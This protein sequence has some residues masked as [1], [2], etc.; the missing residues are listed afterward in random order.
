MSTLA[1]SATNPQGAG[2]TLSFPLFSNPDSIVGLLFG[3]DIDLVNFNAYVNVTIP[4]EAFSALND[5]FSSVS[6]LGGGL[7]FQSSLS[8]N[9][10]LT[11]GYDTYGLRGAC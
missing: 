9:G 2:A 3:Q 6:Y 10:S 4:T 7:G 1:Q 11:V 5:A 8:L